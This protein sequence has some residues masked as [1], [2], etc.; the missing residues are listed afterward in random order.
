M[1]EEIILKG[2][3][4]GRQRNRFNR[5]LNMMYKPSELAEEIGFSTRQIYRV[6]IPYGCPH[7]RDQRNHLWING[8]DIKNW[9]EEIYPRNKLRKDQVFCLTCKKPVEISNPVTKQ[10][11][12][13]IFISCSCPNCERKLVKI[14]GNTKKRK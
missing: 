3:L 7:D 11:N 6:Y 1:E 9:Y 5:L 8:K 4:N 14:I 10:K 2:R 13:V 12:K